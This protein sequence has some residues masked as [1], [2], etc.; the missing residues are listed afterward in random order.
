MG[1]PMPNLT[2]DD[3][4][5]LLKDPT[6]AARVQA[7]NKIAQLH[8]GAALA[9]NERKLAEAIFR[10][11]LRNADVAARAAL[12]E[13]LKE[14]PTVPHDVAL[15]L[16]RDVEQVALPMLHYSLVFTDEDLVELV[17]SRPAPFQTAIARRESVSENVSQV[18]VEHGDETVVT[19]LV[20]NPDAAVT[21]R[22][23]AKVIDLFSR[24]EIVMDGLAQRPRLSLTL[25]E[26]LVTLVS[27]NIRI[28]LANAYD[29]PNPHTERLMQLAREKATM[30]LLP[31][32]ASAIEVDRFVRQLR[33]K[34]RLTHLI[35][36]RGLC[37][38]DL[39]FFRAALAALCGIPTE[40]AATLI[41]DTGALG[42]RS[43][44]VQGR[45]TVSCGERGRPP[46]PRGRPGRGQAR[47]G[48]LRRSGSRPL[49]RLPRTPEHRQHRDPPRP[50]RRRRLQPARAHTRSRRRLT[51]HGAA[52]KSSTAWV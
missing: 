27:E 16:A 25:A 13:H 50:P 26:R 48:T 30:E 12:A 20:G 36:V 41:H 31:A 4:E 29:L 10:T 21:D 42:L 6:P 45:G 17:R 9:P 23:A 22:V 11:M 52:R 34:E 43:V 1:L 32:D 3:I 51:R 37:S 18:L 7:A 47:P 2:E 8:S 49:P 46:R 15:A 19:T 39:P 24:C 35:M 38:G 28:Q 40:N 14:N 33:V 5:R 44:R